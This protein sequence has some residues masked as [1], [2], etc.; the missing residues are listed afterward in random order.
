MHSIAALPTTPGGKSRASSRRSVE[1]KELSKDL[2]DVGRRAQHITRDLQGLI[3][4]H[5]VNLEPRLVCVYQKLFVL[6]HLGE[7]VPVGPDVFFGSPRWSHKWPS[8]DLRR[9]AEPHHRLAA[10]V[11]HEVFVHRK[12]G[13]V[14]HRGAAA[15][16]GAY[17]AAIDKWFRRGVRSG[18]SVDLFALDREH[19]IGAGGIAAD[20]PEVKLRQGLHKNRKVVGA[21]AGAG[22]PDADRRTG[23]QQ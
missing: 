18:A 10:R 6:R 21:R 4:A 9:G 7:G 11:G 16:D 8:D 19:D 20:D 12:L 1:A 15:Y 3:A 22:G 13:D 14:R 2:H 17:Q 5:V 23:L